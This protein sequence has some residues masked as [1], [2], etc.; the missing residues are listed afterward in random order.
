[1]VI[2]GCLT[3]SMIY[4]FIN[5]QA[6]L[7]S[8]FGET[9]TGP[10]AN[11]VVRNWAVLITL[12]GVM[13]IYG[14]FVPAVRNFVLVI[15]TIHKSIFVGLVIVS[16]YGLSG[17]IWGAIAADAAMVVIFLIYFFFPKPGF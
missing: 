2:A 10:T 12:I 13:L 11:V 15:A 6:S 8:M 1:M 7:Q 14:A 3:C 16:G 9:L 4:T 17:Q 5:P